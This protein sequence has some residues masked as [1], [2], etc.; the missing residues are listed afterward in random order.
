MESYLVRVMQTT[1]GMSISQA[2]AMQEQQYCIAGWHALW[3]LL[4]LSSHTHTHARTHTHTHC[5]LS[6]W[7]THYTSALG[8][9][10][11]A[12]FWNDRSNETASLYNPMIF[13]R[14]LSSLTQL[15]K[16]QNNREHMTEDISDLCLGELLDGRWD[17]TS[18]DP[19]VWCLFRCFTGNC[20]V[21][22]WHVSLSGKFDVAAC[23]GLWVR[24]NFYFMQP[25]FDK[26]QFL[27]QTPPR[28]LHVYT[29]LT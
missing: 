27:A 7:S 11:A 17:F 1:Y 20:F 25:K 4:K 14:E 24:L 22:H 29:W 2:S 10:A 15:A 19:V 13:W 8:R 12:E 28:I 26:L 23:W 9:L 6:T 21:F 18:R 16:N 3:E 5:M